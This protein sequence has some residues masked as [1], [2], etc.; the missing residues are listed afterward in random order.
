MDREYW[1][2]RHPE[3]GLRWAH[4]L[5]L[6]GFSLHQDGRGQG[7]PPKGWGPEQRLLSLVLMGR[8]AAQIK[9]GFSEGEGG[10]AIEKTA[11]N[12]PV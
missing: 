7:G 3:C 6:V 5:G 9:S 12:A 8:I 1:G 4:P 11:L 2:T 10:M